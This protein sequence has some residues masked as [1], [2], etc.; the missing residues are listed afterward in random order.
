MIKRAAL[1]TGSLI[2]SAILLAASLAAEPAEAYRFPRLTAAVL[3][4]LSLVQLLRAFG[5]QIDSPNGDRNAAQII[6]ALAMI[7]VY[8]LGLEA[9]GFYLMSGLFFLAAACQYQRGVLTVRTLARHFIVTLLFMAAMF[10]LFG[11][12]LQ[13]Q[14][15]RGIWL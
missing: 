8:L 7:A 14:T 2:V 12:L 13:V 6:P 5:G 11:V 1:A 4:A 9:V 15:P 3:T 10:A